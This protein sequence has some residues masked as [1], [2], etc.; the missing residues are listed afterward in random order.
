MSTTEAGS[1]VNVIMSHNLHEVHGYNRMADIARGRVLVFLQDDQL[2][3]TDCGWAK[4]LL[5]LFDRWPKLGGVGLNY[6]EY[7]YPYTLGGNKTTARFTGEGVYFRDRCGRTRRRSAFV[8]LS[9]SL[10]LFQSFDPRN[11]HRLAF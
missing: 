10:C 3:P 4:D 5:A 8:C 11:I 7:W 9:I 2:P 1:F 6:A